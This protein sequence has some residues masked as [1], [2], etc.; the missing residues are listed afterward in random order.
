M[1]LFDKDDDLILPTVKQGGSLGDM[2]SSLEERGQKYWDIH[3]PAHPVP[4]V[5]PVGQ[6]RGPKTPQEEMIDAFC[7]CLE[8]C[9]LKVQQPTWIEPT[10]TSVRIDKK[11][12]AGSP[13]LLPPGTYPTPAGFTDVLCIDI[14]DLAVGVLW[15]IG[16]LLEDNQDFDVVEWREIRDGATLIDGQYCFQKADPTRMHRDMEPVPIILPPLTRFCL[17]ARNTLLAGDPKQATA[18][19]TGHLIPIKSIT[20]DGLYSQFCVT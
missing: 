12:K 17:Q 9:Y 20:A 11:T 1:S 6:P 8:K 7:K 14:P 13:V 4:Q 15:G 16:M 18:R 10:V 2:W 19:I 5:P 3:R